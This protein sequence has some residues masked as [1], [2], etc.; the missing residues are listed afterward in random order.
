MAQFN[1]T[2]CVDSVKDGTDRYYLLRGITLGRR[3]QVVG[4]GYKA[5]CSRSRPQAFTLIEL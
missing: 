5:A 2:L 4:R 1:G 3:K